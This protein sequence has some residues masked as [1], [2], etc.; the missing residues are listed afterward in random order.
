MALSVPT[1]VASTSFDDAF[2]T[3]ITS[4]SFTPTA[5]SLLIAVGSGAVGSGA[6]TLVS[7]S[8]T[9]TGSG[10]WTPLYAN[11]VHN[12][13]IVTGLAYAKMGASP[14]AGTVTMTF[15]G[16]IVGKK[17]VVYEITGHD[18]ATPV[19]QSATITGGGVSSRTVTLGASPAADS[20]V[21][22]VIAAFYASGISITPGSGF[23]ELNDAA[24]GTGGTSIILQ[25]QYDQ[26][27]A[28]TTCDWTGLASTTNCAAVAIEI[29]AAGGGSP[30]SPYPY[31][32][33]I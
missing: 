31:S 22:G 26:D 24:Q 30:A 18:T 5:N 29:A 21:F 9:H 27:S 11:G 23:S 13:S 12:F 25:Q 10:S 16:N 7:A 17:I 19:I 33:C 6:R 28:D 1:I 15:D 20:L 4:P 3:T 32:I 14:G 2:V 8:S